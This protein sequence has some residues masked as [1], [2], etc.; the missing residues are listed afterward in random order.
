MQ[1]QP[2]Q[3]DLAQP[4]Q[5]DIADLYLESNVLWASAVREAGNGGPFSS[6]IYQVA[7]LDPQAPTPVNLISGGKIFWQIDGMKV[8]A[9][10]APNN[11]FPNSSLAIGTEDEWFHGQW[12]ALFP[13]AGQSPAV[14]VPVTDNVTEAVHE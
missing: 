6:F 12:R 9:L 1:V 8:E 4:A 2:P 14:P 13:P 10:A 7:L 11:L 5:R 3:P